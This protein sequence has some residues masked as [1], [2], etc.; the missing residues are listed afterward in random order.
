MPTGEVVLI[1]VLAVLL[2]SWTALV[3][4]VSSHL[5]MGEPRSARSVSCRGAGSSSAPG[6]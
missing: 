3:L 1:S 4:Y 2:G 5:K 6:N